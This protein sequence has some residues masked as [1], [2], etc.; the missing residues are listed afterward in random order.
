LIAITGQHLGPAATINAQL[1]ATGRLPFVLGSTTVQF[2]GA[3]APLLSVQ[4]GLI[5]CVAPFEISGIT[6]LTVNVDG[7][8]SQSL[9][10]QV[11][12]TVP[13]VL[14]LTNQDG[15]PN[16]PNHPAPQG[17]VVTLYMTGLGVTTPLS[18]DGTV[19]AAPLPAPVVPLSASINGTTVPIQFGGA[20]YGLLA[21]IAQVNVY[22]PVA[23]YSQTP[24]YIGVN[25]GQV[26]IY[27]GQ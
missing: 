14:S 19:N 4:D 26:A 13:Y 11:S 21:G 20:A 8:S 16:G 27:I 6:E 3:V 1:D 23:K 2:N 12:Q 24:S 18:Q 22:V 7:Q 25:S 15:T 17:S 5:V 10:V 9:R